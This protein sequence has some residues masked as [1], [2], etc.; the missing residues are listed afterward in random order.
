M[1]VSMHHG[2]SMKTMASVSIF[3]K[4]IILARTNHTMSL[5]NKLIFLVLIGMMTIMAWYAMRLTII[6]Q[7]KKFGYG[8]YRVRV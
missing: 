7:E 1:A 4:K 3:M 2:L 5:E 6:K 8:A